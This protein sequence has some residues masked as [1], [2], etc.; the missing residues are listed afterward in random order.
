MHTKGIIC[1]HFWQVM[2]YSSAARFHI[3]I[4]PIRWYKNEIFVKLDQALKNLPSLIA[5]ESLVNTANEINLA[6]QTSRNFQNTNYQA[7]IQQIAPQRNRFRSHS[8]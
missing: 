7:S 6:L 3:S 5:I 8:Q 4:I 1:H 2:L